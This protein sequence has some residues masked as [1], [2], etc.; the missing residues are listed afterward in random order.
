MGNQYS[1]NNIE[2]DLNKVQTL[3]N[4]FIDSCYEPGEGYK[5]TPNSEVSPYALCFAIFG[6]YLIGEFGSINKDQVFFDS[7]LRSNLNS[8][9]K[10]CTL[11]RKDIYSNKGYLQLLTFTLS[12]LSAIGTL[13]KDPLLSHVSPIILN[14]NVTNIL[15]TS[16]V[17]IGK[18]GTGN[19][20]MFYA[21]LL[22]HSKKYLALD[23]DEMLDKWIEMHLDSMNSNGFWGQDNKLFYLQFQ[24]GYHQ[25]EIFEYLGIVPD[26][27]SKAANLVNSL[28]DNLGHF[29]PYPGG[30]GC[31]DYD[32]IF[33]LTFLGRLVD[34][35]H[36]NLL[37]Q[38]FN[39]ILSEQNT[40]GGFSESRYVRPININNL[41]FMYNHIAK[42]T[43]LTELERIRYC[44]TLLRPK[45]NR[46]KTHWTKYSREWHESNLWD[47]WFRMLT[48]ARIDKSIN[49]ST[50][51]WGFIDYPGI[52]YSYSLN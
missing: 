34:L 3:Y 12:A 41:K 6:K 52:G 29:A 2:Q 28:S 43:R 50:V 39:T 7:L 20:A 51:N 26:K 49:Q 47:S 14:K 11:E 13:D 15:E 23:V 18:P 36:K 46:I 4:G 27:I 40:D 24:N 25:Y 44:M 30:G 31:Y 21:V 37:K 38:T 17:F 33:V 16:G 22:L 9:K 45:H 35:E 48:I 32:A 42:R 8:Y 19:L 10:K 1:A 5:L